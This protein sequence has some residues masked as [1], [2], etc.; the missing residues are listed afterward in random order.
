MQ[1]SRRQKFL[2]Y[3]VTNL[4][5]LLTVVVAATVIVS[6]TIKP[7]SENDLGTLLAA[8]LSVMGLM[9]ISALWS[10]KL[11]LR[12]IEEF[13][14]RTAVI[15]E[16]R[17]AGTP[18]AR[19]YLKTPNEVHGLHMATTIL[20]GGVVLGRAMRV[21]SSQLKEKLNSG[22]RVQIMLLDSADT[23]AVE[24]FARRS[25]LPNT[26]AAFWRTRLEQNY[27]VIHA[28]GEA[29]P[30]TGGIL[31]IGY[32]PYVPSF[33]LLLLNPEQSDGFCAV[34]IYHHKIDRPEPVL[35]L[36]RSK[37][38][39][40][41]EFFYQQWNL[42]WG[43]CRTEVYPRHATRSKRSSARTKSRHTKSSS[44]I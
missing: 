11:Q 42:L 12:R 39:D 27:Q 32:L 9:A 14:E 31:E 40:W 19:H 23:I 35:H 24:S 4:P 33:G 3:L 10:R 20:I 2:D 38:S 22:A 17:L 41:F 1:A 21:Y 29:I 30:D 16:E 7:P 34:K 5:D 6:Y 36:S 28:I 25:P 18:L 15:V 26:D 37:D 13:S 43:D 8:L 44:S